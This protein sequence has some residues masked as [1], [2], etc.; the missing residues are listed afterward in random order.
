MLADA[1]WIAL[2]SIGRAL[3]KFPGDLTGALLYATE[4]HGKVIGPF[5]PKRAAQV[6]EDL[7]KRVY[8]SKEADH[9]R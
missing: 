1:V 5:S 8:G 6:M 9:E 4:R 3:R 7:A 2:D